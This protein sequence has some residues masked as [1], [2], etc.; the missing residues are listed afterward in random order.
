MRSRSPPEPG[1][2]EG[3]E[4]ADAGTGLPGQRPRG[5][6][7]R[8]VV[9]RLPRHR[10]HA[11]CPSGAGINALTGCA[12]Q[13]GYAVYAGRRYA[14]PPKPPP[15]LHSQ[16]RPRTTAIR[17]SAGWTAIGVPST[18]ESAIGSTRPSKRISRGRWRWARSEYF[19]LQSRYSLT[20]LPPTSQVRAANPIL[21]DLLGGSPRGRG[22]APACC[23]SLRTE[24]GVRQRMEINALVA[25]ACGQATPKRIAGQKKTGQVLE[26]AQFRGQFGQLVAVQKQSVQVD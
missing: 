15:S 10:C 3:I 8:R 21:C 13:H 23:Q 5:R 25:P 12:L 2:P 26:L 24:W 11:G 6:R 9:R 17:L 20:T 19:I 1:E 22:D 7:H 16:L 18:Q 4:V 14:A